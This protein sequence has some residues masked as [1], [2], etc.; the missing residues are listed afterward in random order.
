M[1]V[2]TLSWTVLVWTLVAASVACAASLAAIVVLRSARAWRTRRLEIARSRVRPAV[3]GVLAAEED[4][5]AEAVEQ[6]RQLPEEH[7]P[8]AER[9]VL[10]TLSEVRGG[11]RD[12]LVRLLVDRGTMSAAMRESRG[13]SAIRRARAA[14]VLGLLARPDA[15]R[16]LIQLTAD[17]S[18]D[19]RIVAVR[20]L[21]SLED[22]ALTST[23][24]ATL[25]ADRSVPA[26]V[27]GTALLRA[28]DA[29]TDALRDGLGS[30][31]DSVRATSAAV[32]GH[33]LVT[34]LAAPI[35]ALLEHDPS[36]VVRSAAGRS[37]D[38][39]GRGDT[40]DSEVYG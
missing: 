33:L 30:T 11:S 17:P 18:R 1:T 32:V 22:P 25:S 29:D 10:Q 6:L 35:S 31:S 8:A 24:L 23:I 9:Y 28:R 39:F 16:R 21:G 34:E 5:L 37:L 27:V 7:W 3:L 19:V 26:S 38:R 40:T 13:R 36:A 12:A 20:A 4:E 14:E 2:V 15:R